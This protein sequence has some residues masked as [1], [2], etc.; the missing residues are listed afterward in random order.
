MSSAHPLVSSA[1]AFSLIWVLAGCGGGGSSPAPTPTPAAAPAI[2][3]FTAAPAT[4]TVGGSTNLAF[5]FSGG[6]GVIDQGVGAVSS[7]GAKAVNPAVS[8]TYT[9]TVTP[10]TGTAIIG[11]ATVTVVAAPTI[12]VFTV[13]PTSVAAGSGAILSFSFAGGTGT[14][15]QGL[16]TVSSGGTK[17]V[18]PLATTT[19]TL[20]VTNAAGSTLSATATVTVVAAPLSHGLTYLGNGSTSGTPPSD[21]GS[22][23]AGA[24]V[25]VL[26][27]T[28]GLVRT[29][30]TFTGWN[31]AADGS[32]TSYAPGV[33]LTMGG[34][35]LLLYAQWTVT[36]HAVSVW[37]GA[38]EC[39]ALKSDGTVW[40]WGFNNYGELGDGTTTN[41]A[42][43]LQVLGS[44]GSGHLSG[45]SAI[46]GGEVHNLA[47]KSDGTVWAW[48]WNAM[49][50]VGDGTALT[51]AFPVQV[52][53]LSSIVSLGSRGYHSL[54]VKSDGTVWAW[55]WD[56]NGALGNGVDDSN[57][58]FPVPLQV[59]GVVNPIMVSGGYC[60]SVALLQ[61]HTLVAWGVNSAGQLG[62][63]TTTNRLSPVPVVGLSHVV[64]VSAGW[65][66]VVALKDDG[67]V[68]TW[69]SNT[70]TGA[71]PGSGKLG[72]G[73][74]LDHALPAQVPGLSGAVA[75]SGGD[76]HTAVLKAD[77]TVWTFGSNAAGQCGDGTLTQRLSPV[78]VLGLSGIT[79]LTARDF[80]NQAIQS[81]GTVWSWGSGTS[82]E[83]GNG[84]VVDSPVPVKV[85]PF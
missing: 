59:P 38:R 31:S 50:M 58:D 73:T 69:G 15:D 33:T 30:S 26:G 20:T 22:Y 62:D 18:L 23:P 78:Q 4:L 70:W 80:H 17:N 10:A 8:T 60:F 37:G 81:D 44:G 64:A 28:G 68:W 34:A 56:R 57:S 76:A 79:S 5:T 13:G 53:G 67:T 3:A 42:T 47:L 27:N 39:I 12:S 52:S 63:G 35:N 46:M 72:D 51:R 24:T 6:T 54:A 66:H 21:S 65:T 55:G 2:T 1:L 77:G 32:G 9:L 36:P 7:G 41:S 71:Y 74:T 25:T 40:T 29:G 75:V 19:Y 82:G 14:L 48:G 84:A 45:V 49:N 16:G 43:P 61:D 11:L 83:L 85:L